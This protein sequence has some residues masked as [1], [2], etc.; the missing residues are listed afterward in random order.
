LALSLPLAPRQ[1]RTF[2][3]TQPNVFCSDTRYTGRASFRW[4]KVLGREEI[5]ALLSE[6]FGIGAVREIRVEERTRSAY[7]R[8]VHITGEQGSTTVR[9]DRIRTLLGGLR[10]N[11]FMILPVPGPEKS[12]TQAW[13]VWGGGWGHG[14]GFCQSGAAAMGDKGYTCTEILQ[15][16]FPG[17]NLQALPWREKEQQQVTRTAQDETERGEIPMEE[18]TQN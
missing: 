15:H 12:E 14:V 1:I 2:L 4:I 11:L 8:A 9:G 7:V 6:R 5:N 13:V 16:Y 10:S 18:A 17:T 3:V